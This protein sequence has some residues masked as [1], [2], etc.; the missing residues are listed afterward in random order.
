MV[1]RPSATACCVWCALI[2]WSWQ[3]GERA[4]RA[5]TSRSPCL[6]LGCL[7]CLWIAWRTLTTP[8]RSLAKQ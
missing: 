8:S 1:T 2:Q 5:R 4:F 7:W 6:P 3:A